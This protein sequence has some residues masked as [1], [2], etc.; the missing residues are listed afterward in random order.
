MANHF[1]CFYSYFRPSK[2]AHAYKKIWFKNVNESLLYYTRSQATKLN[3]AIGNKII[4]VD[5]AMRYGNQV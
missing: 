3:N 4:K 2:T 1:K 5:F